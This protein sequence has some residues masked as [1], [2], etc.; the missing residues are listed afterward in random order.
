MFS[1]LP[2][3]TIVYKHIHIDVWRHI[4]KAANGTNFLYLSYFL[5]GNIFGKNDRKSIFS[6][7]ELTELK[8]VS[9]WD[10]VLS[11]CYHCVRFWN[12]PEIYQALKIRNLKLDYAANHSNYVWGF[13]WWKSSSV[14]LLVD[15][16]CINMP[17]FA[18]YYDL[19]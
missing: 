12:F 3:T 9:D 2:I 8:E 13:S 19:I 10:W 14:L 15:G 18:K 7:F 16:N 5:H 4:H 6:L 11:L 17:K 1:Q